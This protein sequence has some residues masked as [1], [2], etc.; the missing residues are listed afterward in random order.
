MEYVEA[1][2]MEEMEKTHVFKIEE[3][4]HELTSSITIPT[5]GLFV[6]GEILRSPQS[7]KPQTLPTKQVIEKELTLDSNALKAHRMQ[8]CLRNLSPK[9][10]SQFKKM[11]TKLDLKDIEFKD[12]K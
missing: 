11:S 8:E 9:Q 7:N 3:H 1:S 4:H 12:L 2:L 10:E 5:E 6:L